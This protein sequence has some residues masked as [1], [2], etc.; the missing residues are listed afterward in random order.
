[1]TYYMRAGVTSRG[2]LKHT[3]NGIDTENPGL[4]RFAK[5]NKG[6]DQP[7]YPRSLI[8]L[9]VIRLM[10]NIIYRLAMSEI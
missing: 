1:M 10:N 8:S 4:R 9:I 3:H 5:K 7:A 6:K 2:I